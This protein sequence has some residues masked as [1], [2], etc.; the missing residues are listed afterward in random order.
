MKNFQILLGVLVFI[1]VFTVCPAFGADYFILFDVH[2]F[3]GESEVVQ[4]TQKVTLGQDIEDWVMEK[5]IHELLN[6]PEDLE[7]VFSIKDDLRIKFFNACREQNKL[8]QLQKC[9]E[10][11]LV[12]KRICTRDEDSNQLKVNKSS[13]LI[14]VKVNREG[15][16]PFAVM[17][18]SKNRVLQNI[19]RGN[20]D[21]WHNLVNGDNILTLLGYP[22][23]NVGQN[24]KGD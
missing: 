24:I 15:A 1:S 20:E 4:N 17:A 18:S 3:S 2:D 12:E 21:E 10:N 6:L 16:F 9:V 22:D 7:G 13:L 23:D 11:I 19:V 8:V 14:N 5:Y